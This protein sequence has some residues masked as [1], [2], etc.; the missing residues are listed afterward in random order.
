MDLA[1]VRRLYA[2][3]AWADGLVFD[4]AAALSDEERRRHLE[5]SFPSV[6]AT[7]E[8]VVAAEWIWLQRWRGDNPS[9]PP[10]WWGDPELDFLRAKLSEIEA[11][12]D[13]YLD[14]LEADDLTRVLRY[15]LLSGEER[16]GP[17][18]DLLL[19]VVNHSTY[20][21]GQL[22]TLLRQL[23]KTPPA[24]DLLWYTDP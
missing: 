3:T 23:G 17:L 12:R 10:D 6:L 19:H 4:A 24:T 22:V 14:R 2:Y 1:T 9:A 21:R 20:H 7:L 18:G 13:A 11:E 8:H 5:S 15:R 16:Q